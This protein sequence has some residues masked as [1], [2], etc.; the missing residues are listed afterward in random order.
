[1]DSD[2]IDVRDVPIRAEVT[3]RGDEVIVDL[4]GIGP[5]VHAAR[6][7]SPR[8]FAQASVYQ[9]EMSALKAGMFPL[10]AGTFRPITVITKPGT[11]THGGRYAPAAS[12]MRGSRG[13][14]FSI[15]STALWPISFPTV[16][17]RRA[18]EAS[19]CHHLQQGSA[20]DPFILSTSWLSGHGEL[21]PWRMATTACRT[22]LRWPPTS[23]LRSPKRS[24]RS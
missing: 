2:G 7:T 24:S 15:P 1:M 19:C 9:T 23:P 13:F 18:R 8:S 5:M 11:V 10:T 3:V 17:P 22:R 14:G 16:S 21:G 20:G 12:S 6:R 4:S